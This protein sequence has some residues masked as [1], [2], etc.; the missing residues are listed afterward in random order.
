MVTN[1]G[2]PA[3]PTAVLFSAGLDSAVLLAQAATEGR[4]HPIYVRAGP[5][6]GSARK[7]AAAARLLAAPPFAGAVEPSRDADRG[8]ARRL[9][10]AP[11]GGPRAKPRHS[12]RR[13]RTSTSTDATSSCSRKRRSTWLEPDCRACC[14]A[15][16]PAT[17]FPTPRPSSS[18]RWRA[19]CRSGLDSPIVD[20]NA[21]GDDAQG[22]RDQAGSLAGRAVRADAVVHAA[23][24]W[25]ALRPLQQVPRAEGWVLEA[26]I[27]RIRRGTG[28]GRCG[29]RVAER[30]G[31]RA[32]SAGFQRDR[33]VAGLDP[34]PL[35][36]LT[37]A[38]AQRAALAFVES[39][40]SE[41]GRP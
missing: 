23:E 21:V 20:R 14:S 12:T 27:C 40:S 3:Q 35:A 1:G 5:G 13:T 36:A 26:R 39:R 32:E 11:L 41:R 15:R 24:G 4:A 29:R 30:R 7:R 37:D 8:H 22:G 31:V 19:R 25:T 33:A 28:S 10:A 18:P 6:V 38:T 34:E 9:S 2:K 16:S 17:R